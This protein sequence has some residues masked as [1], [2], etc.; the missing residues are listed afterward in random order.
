MHPYSP[1]A[2]QYS[3]LN[4]DD[5]IIFSNMAAELD[6]VDIVLLTALPEDAD[7]TNAE[8]AGLSPAPPCTGCGG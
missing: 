8:L 7:R 4:V 6:D 1:V 5:E 2:I 3:T